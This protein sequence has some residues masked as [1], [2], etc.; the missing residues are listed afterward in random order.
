MGW[1][2]A[3][4]LTEVIVSDFKRKPGKA[5]GRVYMAERHLRGIY[6][7]RMEQSLGLVPGSS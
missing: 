2:P 5:F 4:P 1:L 3:F 7:R 6:R